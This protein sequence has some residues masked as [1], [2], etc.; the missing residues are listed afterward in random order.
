MLC[1]KLARMNQPAKGQLNCKQRWR[2]HW[3]L[4]V[5]KFKRLESIKEGGTNLDSK[6][7]VRGNGDTT[8][9]HHRAHGC[10]IVLGDR[11]HEDQ[12]MSQPERHKKPTKE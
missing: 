4:E 8:F 5:T 11:L 7:R 9:S 2:E 6:S 3:F 10:A 12:G 1:N